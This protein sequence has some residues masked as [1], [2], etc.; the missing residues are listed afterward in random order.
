MKELI[1]KILKEGELDWIK[2]EPINP[3]MIYNTIIFDIEPSKKDIVSYIKMAL[4]TKKI[5]NVSLWEGSVDFDANRIIKY[6]KEYGSSH[7]SINEYGDLQYGIYPIESENRIKYSQLI[8]EKGLNESDDGLDWIRNVEA[9]VYLQPNTVYYFN[10]PLGTRTHDK[11]RFI[12]N[13]KNADI[14]KQMLYSVVSDKPKYIG[15]TQDM[16]VSGWC[17]MTSIGEARRMYRD[18]TFVDARK[19]F[20]F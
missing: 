6:F 12:D 3:W 17:N 16:E 18:Y 14:I 4:Q 9:G 5:G 15:I 20:F 10:P 7:L 1:K 11:E 19:Q 2:Q 8:N 13:I